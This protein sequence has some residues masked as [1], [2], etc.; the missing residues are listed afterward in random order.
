MIYDVLPR[1]QNASDDVVAQWR[2][3]STSTLGHLTE[4]GFLRGIRPL[5]PGVSL[6]GNV[7]T[8]RLRMPDG[9]ALREALLLSQPGDVLVIDAMED[10]ERACWGELRTLAAQ[11]KG[12]AGVIVSGAVTDARALRALGWPVFCR[13]ISAITTRAQGTGGEV[14]HPIV[15]SGVSVLPGDMALADD[16]GVFVLSAER[17]AHWLLPA[18]EKS[19]ADAERRDDLMRRRG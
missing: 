1:R 12:V 10:A 17:A 9:G 8:A 4:E 16:D 11:V 2:E 19:R 18:R 6:A 15:V 3:I 14:N 5:S 13:G 7:V